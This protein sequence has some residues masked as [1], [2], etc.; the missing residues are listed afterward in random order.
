MNKADLTEMFRDKCSRSGYWRD[1]YERLD[2]ILSM[3]ADVIAANPDGVF[4]PKIGSFQIRK[5][6]S[7]HK[8][9]TFVASNWLLK[10]A[11]SKE[12]GNGDGA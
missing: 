7:G 8:Y 10:Q 1:D 6:G 5:N 2:D 11:H 9:A 4:I 3:L 12:R